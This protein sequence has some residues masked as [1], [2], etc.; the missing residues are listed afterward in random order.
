MKSTLFVK[1]RRFLHNKVVVN[2]VRN[3]Y[4]F[5]WKTN[6]GAGSRISLSVKIDKEYPQGVVIGEYTAVTF[7]VA[8]L[9]HDFVN[10][11]RTTT[12]IGSHC[13]IGARSMIMAGVTIGDQ[14]II[15][16][17]SV[18]LR[19]VPANSVVMGN[20]ARVIE[21]DVKLARWGKR[22]PVEKLAAEAEVTGTSIDHKA[23]APAA[24][25]V[26]ETLGD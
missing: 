1:I 2:G 26:Q 15:G 25:A 19:D 5:V 8:I 20:P 21:R 18:V 24:A 6:I 11:Y 10:G 4:N 14:C 16:A 17:G 13:F 7:G 9:T 3:Y 23:A 12:T 22:I